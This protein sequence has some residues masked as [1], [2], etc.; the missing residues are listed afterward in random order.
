MCDHEYTSL[1]GR[2]AT[3]RLVLLPSSDGRWKLSVEAVGE[4]G[5]GEGSRRE[6]DAGKAGSVST[7]TC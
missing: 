4:G 2:T 6:G 7:A 5:G 3:G 1:E